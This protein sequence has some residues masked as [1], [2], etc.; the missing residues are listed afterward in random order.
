[1]EAVLHSPAGHRTA[2]NKLMVEN[3]PTLPTYQWVGY[4][5]APIPGWLASILPFN[6][7]VGSITPPLLM[8]LMP[9]HPALAVREG[10]WRGEETE[11]VGFGE[12]GHGSLLWPELALAAPVLKGTLVVLEADIDGAAVTHKVLGRSSSIITV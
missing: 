11:V 3:T 2:S 6:P 5:A 4:P 9:V 12:G 8:A 7:C 1:M 10:G